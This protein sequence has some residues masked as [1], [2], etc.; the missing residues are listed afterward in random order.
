MTTSIKT[1]PYEILLR[2]NC[3]PGE[4][5]SHIRGCHRLMTSYAVDDNG[6]ITGRIHSNETAADFPPEELSKYLGD[7]FAD[8]VHQIDK[9]RAENALLQKQV[10]GLTAELLEARDKLKAA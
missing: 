5:F 6:V 8:M 1:G 10:A 7:E 4:T 9:E 3:E 2:F